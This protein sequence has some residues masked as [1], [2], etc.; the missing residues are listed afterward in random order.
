MNRFLPFVFLVSV[1]SMFGISWIIVSVDPDAKPWA[2]FAL[3][4]L[5]LFIFVFSA[6]GLFFYFLRTK[7]LRRFSSKWYFNTSFKMAAFI[8]VF[9]TLTA[10]L[11]ALGLVT[12]FNLFLLIFAIS[13]F[14]I[15]S[16][17]GKK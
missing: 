17:L 5:L 8:A 14:A 16:Y 10:V 12:L 11:A 15:W 3:F 4:F 13:L 2:I 7:F 6:L 9:I 1:A